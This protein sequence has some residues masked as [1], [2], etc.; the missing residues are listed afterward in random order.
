MKICNVML[1]KGHRLLFN[2]NSK[3]HAGGVVGKSYFMTNSDE[4]KIYEN[5][6]YSLMINSFLVLRF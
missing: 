3:I 5:V 1:E 6:Y 2:R 4:Y